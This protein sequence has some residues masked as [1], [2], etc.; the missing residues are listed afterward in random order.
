MQLPVNGGYSDW[1]PEDGDTVRNNEYTALQSRQLRKLALQPVIGA[2]AVERRMVELAAAQLHRGDDIFRNADGMYRSREAARE[3]RSAICSSN[4]RQ[5]N[6]AE[7]RAYKVLMDFNG[8]Y[9]GQLQRY[10]ATTW[11]RAAR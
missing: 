8:D 2:I 10:I 4:R 6:H 5:L 1:N 11:E 7:N 3:I 9:L